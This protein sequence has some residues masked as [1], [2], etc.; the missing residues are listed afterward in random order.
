MNRRD[1]L[2][3]GALAA[4][5]LVLGGSLLGCA[6][7]AVSRPGT[8]ESSLP[9]GAATGGKVGAN[10]FDPSLAGEVTLA[11]AEKASPAELTRTAINR[12][13]GI[14]TW[15]KPGDRV[16]IKPNLAYAT[17]PPQAATVHPQ[18]LAA[19]L[20]LCNEARAK[21]ILVVEHPLN[22]AEA[23]FGVSGAKEVCQAAGVRLVDL[24][25]AA[26][27]EEV[28]F[29]AG[30]SLKQDQIARDVLECDAY[31]NLAIAKV[32]GASRATLGI[33]NQMGAVWNRQRYHSF[34]VT[35]DGA[36]NLSQNIADLALALRPTLTVIDA[37]RAL[38][39]NGPQGPGRVEEPHTVVVSADP[40]AADAYACRFLGL[41][42]S[43]VVHLRLAAEYGLGEMG[44]ESFKVT[45]A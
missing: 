13:G 29:P 43:E 44:V 5:G 14:S 16:V 3:H 21:E 4:T 22:T 25:K 30:K 2:I 26:M 6:R 37:T 35:R 28:D 42:P 23:A 39:T 33:K 45:A 27:Y 18:V 11:L 1:F 31:I 10:R 15:V 9:E 19:V 12:Y 24:S 17:Q 8:P 38:M 41:E 40:V 34:G 36:D 20:A 7:K 32:H